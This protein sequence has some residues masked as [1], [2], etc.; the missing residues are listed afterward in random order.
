M[1]TSPTR[2]RHF[3][4]RLLAFILSMLQAIM[5]AVPLLTFDGQRLLWEW[6]LDYLTNVPVFMVIIWKFLFSPNFQ[7][8]HSC[9]CST[10]NPGTTYESEQANAHNCVIIFTVRFFV[11]NA[12]ISWSHVFC[13]QNQK[14]SSVSNEISCNI[15]IYSVESNKNFCHHF[16]LIM[17]SSQELFS[18]YKNEMSHTWW[19]FQSKKL[20]ATFG[21]KTAECNGC[22]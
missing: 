3:T 15:Y 11:I 4:F 7:P 10:G 20:N 12:Q 17:N 18:V 5:S 1:P 22:S 13:S 8:R 21:I 16:I 6:T 2:Q 14:K 9:T 19:F